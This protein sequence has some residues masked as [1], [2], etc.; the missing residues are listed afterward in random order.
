MKEAACIVV[1]ASGQ[2]A[3]DMTKKE[4]ELYSTIVSMVI[5]AK[6]A[7]A[8]DMKEYDCTWPKPIIADLD[9]AI[10]NLVLMRPK[11]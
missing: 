2:N 9:E 11:S 4:K 6:S 3:N 7:L 5:S 10:K 1:N 8:S